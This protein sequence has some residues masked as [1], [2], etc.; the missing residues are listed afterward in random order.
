MTLASL[1]LVVLASFLHASWNLLAKR[2]ASAGPVF[3]LAFSLIAWVIYTPWVVWLIWHGGF[4]L[5]WMGAGVLLASSVLHLGYNLCLQRGYQR[6]DLSVVYPVARGTGPMLSTLAAFVVFREPPTSAGVAGLIAVVGGIVL[7]A[8]QGNIAAFRRP[9]GQAGVRWGLAT[10][11]FIASYTVTDAMAVKMLGIAPVVLDWVSNLLRVLMLLPMVLANPARARAAMRGHWITALGVGILSPLSYILVLTALTQGAP[12]SLV[13]PMR[14]M[15][16][17]VGALM[18]M[19]ILRETVGRWRL[20]G[21]AV[22]IGG[23]ILL[24]QG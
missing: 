1:L 13:A 24:S 20:I 21:C 12:L 10:G 4:A 23:V 18:G 19:L 5:S 11:G 16:M 15:S 17:M 7:I 8:T 6:A 2:A 3:V 14:E 9:E 22:L